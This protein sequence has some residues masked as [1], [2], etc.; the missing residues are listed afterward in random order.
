MRMAVAFKT[1]KINPKVIDPNYSGKETEIEVAVES[2]MA[3][4][5]VF[6]DRLKVCSGCDKLMDGRCSA[7]GCAVPAKLKWAMSSCP[8][9]KW[10]SVGVAGVKIEIPGSSVAS[11]DSPN[12]KS[13][14]KS[15]FG[16]VIKFARSGFPVTPLDVL[17]ERLAICGG[18]EHWDAKAFAGT[19]Q[20]NVCG[21]STQTKLRMSTEA[22]PLQKWTRM[23]SDI[24]IKNRAEICKRCEFFDSMA[25]KGN[26]KCMKCD[27]NI[28]LKI[29]ITKEECP[30]GKWAA[31]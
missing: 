10:G 5:D 17:E 9:N 28:A 4:D 16:S 11:I 21:C 23:I 12:L 2:L 6:Q 20:C 26:G 18:C 25:L 31:A 27:C 14:A 15:F 8:E 30:A 29:R 3:G 1:M 13:M 19:G 24:E 7:C 22:C